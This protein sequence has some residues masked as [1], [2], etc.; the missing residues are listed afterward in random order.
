[1]FTKT[2]VLNRQLIIPGGD[3][4]IERSYPVGRKNYFRIFRHEDLNLTI[5]FDP[6]QPR[7]E[8]VC[9]YFENVAFNKSRTYAYR[10]KGKE[11][12]FT[13]K[14][15]LRFHGVTRFKV[16]YLLR[17]KWYWD[18]RPFSYVIVD[19]E[20]LKD[21]RIYTF[22]PNVIGH[23]GDWMQ[24]VRRIKDL[25]YNMIHILPITPMGESE[26]PYAA[27]D[28]IGLDQHFIKPNDSRSGKE[29]LES[30]VDC[31]VKLKMRLC[32]DLVFN[33]I[34]VDSRICR[35][36]PDWLTEDPDEEDGIR[37]GAWHDG[38]QWHKWRDLAFLNYDLPCSHTRDE[39][40]QYMK[41]YA[42]YWTGLAA[43]TKGMIR[44]DNL[45]SS[46]ESFMR[47]VLGEIRKAYPHIIIFG[48][49]FDTE[50]VVEEKAL[51]YGLNFLLGTSW[52]HKF[53]P[54]LRDYIKYTHSKKRKLNYL[55]PINSHDSYS[56]TEEFGSV[57]ATQ[58]RLIVSS[59]LGPGPSGITQ[60]VEF[61]I[62]KKL[63]FIGRQAKV[64]IKGQHD[65]TDLIRNLNK[66]IA[67]NAVFQI[68]GNLEFVDHNHHAI[69]AAYRFDKEKN[70]RFLIAVNLDIHNAHKITVTI[71]LQQLAMGLESMQC[72]LGEGHWELSGSEIHLSLPANQFCIL[73][74]S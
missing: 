42:L 71:P 53:V 23:V 5:K 34:G 39:L 51:Q 57:M 58:S 11:W 70:I 35:L 31:A 69:L 20:E 7:P 55:F 8:K 3:A 33:N 14:V 27:Y 26:S 17:H 28:L 52:E 66:L 73:G 50:D 2:D 74:C 37:R 59:L 24:E 67:D 60:G 32:F 4:I 22:I 62:E 68:P 48:E 65:F 15:P 16:K 10:I 30:F 12:T 38:R 19:P 13:S 44:L 72:L 40:W 61:G 36:R 54:Q 56:P 47:W 25:G 6:Q 41:E 64:I 9:I 21:L 45:H 49:L 63:K 43:K 1:M 29:Q 18:R 46:H